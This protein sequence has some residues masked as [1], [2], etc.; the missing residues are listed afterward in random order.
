MGEKPRGDEP[1]SENKEAEFSDEW[2]T[3]TE[4]GKGLFFTKETIDKMEEAGRKAQAEKERKDAE[5]EEMKEKDIRQRIKE[6]KPGTVEAV[7]GALDL[8]ML[9]S[10]RDLK[11]KGDPSGRLT[12]RLAELQRE[13][14]KLFQIKTFIN[15]DKQQGQ[16]VSIAEVLDRT[17]A[18]IASFS[19]RENLSEEEKKELE[20]TQKLQLRLQDEARKAQQK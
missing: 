13:S 8:T 10:E 11:K 1:K 7:S 5:F 15:I 4:K 3:S 17:G 9:L 18:A 14:A 2:S 20:V 6:A 19:E 16:E 12:A